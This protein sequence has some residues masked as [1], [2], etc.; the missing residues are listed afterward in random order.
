MTALELIRQ[1]GAR[2][3]T[4][5][6]LVEKLKG[7]GITTAGLSVEL[8]AL[9]NSHQVDREAGLYWARPTVEQSLRS[10][11]SRSGSPAPPAA[12]SVK[13]VPAIPV[14]HRRC[15]RCTHVKPLSEFY[16]NGYCRPCGKEYSRARHR[17]AA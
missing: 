15:P 3:V 10:Q 9:V 12:E 2:G 4:H 17:A 8:L 14:G 16:T 5:A 1:A 7:E 13:P 6:E 11:P